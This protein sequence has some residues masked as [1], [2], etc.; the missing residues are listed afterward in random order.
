MGKK[1]EILFF[2]FLA[3]PAAGRRAFS[4]C[5]NT[6]AFVIKDVIFH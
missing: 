6:A 1:K 5:P 4:F 3:K 2:H